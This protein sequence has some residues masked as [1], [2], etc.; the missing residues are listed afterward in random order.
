MLERL[1]GDSDT[2][3]APASPP[4][5]AASR[6]PGGRGM[7]RRASVEALGRV[8]ASAAHRIR[9]GLTG[10]AA[11][12]LLV[13]V[14]AAGMRPSPSVAAAEPQAEPLAVLGV[15]PGAP[16]AVTRPVDAPVARPAKG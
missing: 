8:R 13:M 5:D 10:L 14:A 15:A 11:I 1:F 9:L 6:R 4:V 2:T 7:A 16:P 3:I 12:F